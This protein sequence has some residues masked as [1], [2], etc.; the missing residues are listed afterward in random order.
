MKLTI[1]FLVGILLGMAVPRAVQAVGDG[2]SQYE[3]RQ[4]INL[5]EE[6]A[7]NTSKN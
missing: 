3:I 7:R 1:A 6:I 5:L 4:V 2:W